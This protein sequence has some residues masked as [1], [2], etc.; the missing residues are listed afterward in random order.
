MILRALKAVE[1]VREFALGI[2]ISVLVIEV[3]IIVANAALNF[4]V[5]TFL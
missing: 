2:L 4:L 5:R 3:T 1:P